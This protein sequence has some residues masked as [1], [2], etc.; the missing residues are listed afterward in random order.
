L[1]F[2]ISINSKSSTNYRVVDRASVVR[3]CV[4][5]W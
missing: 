3:F 5:D 4:C 2:I 1:P